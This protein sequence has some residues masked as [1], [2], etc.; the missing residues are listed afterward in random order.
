MTF[1]LQFFQQRFDVPA[2]SRRLN[3]KTMFGLVHIGDVALELSVFDVSDQIH[4]VEEVRR[5]D[6]RVGDFP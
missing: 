2:E 3:V 1:L 4:R 5:N 6:A